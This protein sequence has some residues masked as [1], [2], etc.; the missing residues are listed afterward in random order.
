MDDLA[1]SHLCPHLEEIQIL[2]RIALK[3]RNRLYAA[4]AIPEIVE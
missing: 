1:R 2:Q 3:E 4:T